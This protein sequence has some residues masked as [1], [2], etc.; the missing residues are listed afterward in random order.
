MEIADEFYNRFVEKLKNIEVIIVCL[1]V[2]LVEIWL[3]FG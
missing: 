1:F 2:R 3:D